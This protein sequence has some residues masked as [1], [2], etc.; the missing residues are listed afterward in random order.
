MEGLTLTNTVFIKDNMQDKIEIYYTV[1]SASLSWPMTSAQIE[2]V[3][4]MQ[5]SSHSTWPAS[6]P[7]DRDTRLAGAGILF[8]HTNDSC[9]LD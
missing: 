8:S 4:L 9:T 6:I 1:R 5:E 7:G 3:H 2:T